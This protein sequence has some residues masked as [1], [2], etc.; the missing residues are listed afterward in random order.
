MQCKACEKGTYGHHRGQH[1]VKCPKGQY[2]NKDGE[3]ACGACPEDTFQQREGSKTCTPC[4]TLNRGLHR[5]STHG[6]AGQLKCRPVPLN[7]VLS[8][9]SS[10]GPCSVS[11]GSGTRRSTRKVLHQAWAGGLSCAGQPL[12]QVQSCSNRECGRDCAVTGWS[13]WG[14]CSKEC[15]WGKQ[16]RTRKILALPKNG[17]SSNVGWQLSSAQFS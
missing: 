5:Y 17:A 7:C 1:C 6:D 8:K 3:S 4:K 10:F 13:E 14:L 11:C 12:E 2:Q 15:G 9:W 16:T